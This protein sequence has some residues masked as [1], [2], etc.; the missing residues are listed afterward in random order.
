MTQ[1]AE[2][3]ELTY[4]SNKSLECRL[5][6]WD[7]RVG[8]SGSEEKLGYAIRDVSPSLEKSLAEQ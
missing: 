7:V 3:D 6:R 2:R 8:R 5:V 4:T 1:T